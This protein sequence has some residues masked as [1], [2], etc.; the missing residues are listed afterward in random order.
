MTQK[1]SKWIYYVL[2]AIFM[3]ALPSGQMEEQ[4][5]ECLLGGFS[6]LFVHQQTK[7]VWNNQLKAPCN[8]AFKALSSNWQRRI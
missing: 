8:G 7:Q 3:G 1:Q 6:A 4:F 5:D 2:R